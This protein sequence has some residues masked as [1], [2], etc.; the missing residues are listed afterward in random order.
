MATVSS[1]SYNHVAVVGASKRTRDAV[2]SC[3]TKIFYFSDPNPF[4]AP[5]AV[6]QVFYNTAWRHLAAHTT[7]QLAGPIQ[8]QNGMLI[9]MLEIASCFS[10]LALA[11]AL[12]HGASPSDRTNNTAPKKNEEENWPRLS[13]NGA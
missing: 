5:S 9:R 6:G 10:L 13:P 1:T 2:R 11:L 7:W 8:L 3:I 4:V 12:G